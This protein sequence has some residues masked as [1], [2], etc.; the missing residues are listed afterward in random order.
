M[1]LQEAFE[2]EDGKLYW[3]YSPKYDVFKGNEAGC[4]RLDGY[5]EIC[6]DNIRYLR[7]RVI[8]Y[9]HT[10]EWPALID[11]ID[12]DISN[13]RFENLRPASR[14]LNGHNSTVWSGQ[15]PYRGVSLNKRYQKFEAY[16]RIN[17]RRKFLG[18]HE[19]AEAASHAF[20]T[21]RKEVVGNVR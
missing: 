6:L 1:T 10:S 8:Y 2:Y 7:H 12:R 21:F 17:K 9:L 3:R 19:T 4:I 16:I 13:D 18:Y 15:T 14:S 11:H 5:W 20:E